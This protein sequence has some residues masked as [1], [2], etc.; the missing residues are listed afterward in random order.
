[1]NSNAGLAFD[2]SA[3]GVDDQLPNSILDPRRH[4]EDVPPKFYGT[5]SLISNN[6]R[7][8][9]ENVKIGVRRFDNKR[10]RLGVLDW[11]PN[12]HWLFA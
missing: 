2:E 1:M 3:G 8:D 5:A 4:G 7:V 6:N 12:Y 9:E 10:S 11:S